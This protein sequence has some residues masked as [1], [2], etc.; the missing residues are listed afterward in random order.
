MAAVGHQKPR[1]FPSTP[2]PPQKR[3]V[4]HTDMKSRTDK[5]PD[6]GFLIFGQTT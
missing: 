3:I 6:K 2:F 5:L 4:L 1:E